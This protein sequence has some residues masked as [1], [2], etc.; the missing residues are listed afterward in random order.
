L[1]TMTTELAKQKVLTISRPSLNLK[2][3]QVYPQ[4]I[5]QQPPTSEKLQNS[6]IQAICSDQ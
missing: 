2:Q 5:V 4:F 3:M 1:D 6:T